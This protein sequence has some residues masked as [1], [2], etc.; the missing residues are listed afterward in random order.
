MDGPHGASWEVDMNRNATLA[1]LI[2][3]AAA[4]APPLASAQQPPPAAD[5]PPERA[6]DPDDL[7]G[8]RL[9]ELLDMS[10]YVASKRD[11]KV[12]EAPASITA[13]AAEDVQTL[14]NY[15]IHDLANVTAGY[16]G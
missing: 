13:H 14:G 11:E 9:D 1:V 15:T 8:F 5:P 3:G 10:V 16:S 6:P 4:L 2:A 7:A 12:S